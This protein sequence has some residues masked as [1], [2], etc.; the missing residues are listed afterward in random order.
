VAVA[1]VV[2]QLHVAQRGKAVEPGVGHG[3][4]GLGKAVFADAGDEL[5]ALGVDLDGPG[6]AG[7]DGH[8]A[9]GLAGG[10]FQR[11]GL[12]RQ[13]SRLARAVTAAMKSLRAW[14]A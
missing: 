4:H 3:F 2:V 12:V 11:A 1:Q 6:L 7:D 10:Y 13:P 5:L 9:L 14:G 8:V